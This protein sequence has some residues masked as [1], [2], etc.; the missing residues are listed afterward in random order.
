MKPIQ[1]SIMTAVMAA[2]LVALLSAFI[3]VAQAASH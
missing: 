3:A 2:G 1:E